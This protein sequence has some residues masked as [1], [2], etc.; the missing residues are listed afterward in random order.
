MSR[1]TFIAHLAIVLTSKPLLPPTVGWLLCLSIELRPSKVKGLPI[2]LISFFFNQFECPNNCITLHPTLITQL[3]V[4]PTSYILLLPADCFCCIFQLNDSHLRPG[5][6]PSL[7]F[8]KTKAAVGQTTINQK[9]AGIV[10]ETVVV[11]VTVV[12]APPTAA[13]AAVNVAV[14]VVAT[15]AAVVAAAAAMAYYYD[16]ALK[17]SIPGPNI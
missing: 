6:C 9:A 8:S 12:T 10:G 11:A 14:I 13:E 15:V 2:S 3:A 16:R 7:Y 4:T 5:P 1:P 17:S